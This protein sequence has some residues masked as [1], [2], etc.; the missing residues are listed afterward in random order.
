MYTEGKGVTQDDKE[1][2]KWFRKAAEEGDADG[3]YSLGLMYSVGRGVPT[4]FVYAHMWFN[5]AAATGLKG[6]TEMRERI[7]KLMTRTQIEEAQ[8]LAREWTN[9][10]E[11][12]KK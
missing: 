9:R 6:A 4:D 10:F 8:R 12:R 1:A 2:V 11:N 5:L 7:T 3:Q